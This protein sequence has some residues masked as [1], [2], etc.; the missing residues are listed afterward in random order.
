VSGTTIP[1]GTLLTPV[2]LTTSDPETAPSDG[3]ILLAGQPEVR[4]RSPRFVLPAV[5]AETATF[6][7]DGIT[8]ATSVP[9]LRGSSLQT[10]Q[11]PV[12]ALV[13]TAS[14]VSYAIPLLNVPVGSV[15]RTVASSTVNV[16]T[17]T[18]L[19]T[20]QN[21][22][23]PVGAQPREGTTFQESTFGQTLLGTGTA[24]FIVYDADDIRGNSDAVAEELVLSATNNNLRLTPPGMKVPV[25]VTLG[26]GTT[27]TVRGVRYQSNFNYGSGLT[28]WMFDQAALAADGATVN[29]VT[30]VVSSSTTG[31]ALTWQDLGFDL[32]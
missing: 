4:S 7:I 2:R 25:T 6:R 14:G 15:S 5:P 29:D 28:I 9:P 3:D 17:V 18:S 10:D 26:N 16:S 11:G 30:G 32:F 23:L 13:F 31:H 8:V 24:R 19:I 12:T 20:Y 1:A 21:G 27:Q 22:L